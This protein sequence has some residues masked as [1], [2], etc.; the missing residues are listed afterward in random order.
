MTWQGYHLRM[1][2]GCPIGGV[3]FFHPITV[4]LREVVVTLV[5]G[6]V[7]L[8]F[9]YPPRNGFMGRWRGILLLALYAAYVTTVLLGGAA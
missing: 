5:F 9:V 1:I 4:P 2:N 8:T 6:V 7:A 3:H